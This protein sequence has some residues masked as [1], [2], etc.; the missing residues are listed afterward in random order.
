MKRILLAA[1]LSSLT[2]GAFANDVQIE[3]DGSALPASCKINGTHGT[4]QISVKLPKV[5]IQS[6][7]TAGSWSANTRFTLHLTDCPVG[8][9]VAW[10]APDLMDPAS[11][12]LRNALSTGTN[13]QVRVLNEDF[14]PVDLAK[15]AGRTVSDAESEELTY[16]LQYYAKDVP[17]VQGAFKSS[18]RVTLSR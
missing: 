5:S 15:D 9:I 1:V 8:T 11:G 12:G 2:V 18:A 17:V 10:S 13:A 6:L 4:A 14:S 7:S 16:Y 3:V